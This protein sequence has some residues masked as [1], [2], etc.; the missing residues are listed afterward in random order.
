MFKHVILSMYKDFSFHKKEQ[1]KKKTSGVIATKKRIYSLLT[2][3]SHR[4]V[5]HVFHIFVSWKKL[6]CWSKLFVK[7]MKFEVF[8]LNCFWKSVFFQLLCHSGSPSNQI[9][10]YSNFGDWHIRLSTSFTS[11][12]L[13]NTT[14]IDVDLISAPLSDRF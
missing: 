14:L 13:P 8:K 11:D 9:W 10:N 5:H 1:N 6:L 12:S 4:N 3:E 7:H 2:G